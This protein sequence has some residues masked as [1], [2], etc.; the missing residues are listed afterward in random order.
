MR[1]FRFVKLTGA[2][3]DCVRYICAC[4]LVFMIPFASYKH[5]CSWMQSAP[6]FVKFL[7]RSVAFR[8]GPSQH[9]ASVF[10]AYEI[11]QLKVGLEIGKNE[12]VGDNNG[13]EKTGAF[14]QKKHKTFIRQRVGC[15]GK[16][17]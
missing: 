16:I 15:G 2:C 1:F 12:D 3:F 11:E 5:L 17:K 4:K 13:T 10:S 9:Q 6:H 7:I 14:L 8:Q